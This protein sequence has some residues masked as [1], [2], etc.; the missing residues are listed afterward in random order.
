MGVTRPGRDNERD[1]QLRV[2]DIARGTI[3]KEQ[4]IW[5]KRGSR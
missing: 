1:H 5:E 4:N 2:R 3:E